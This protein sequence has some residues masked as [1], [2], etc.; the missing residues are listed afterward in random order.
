MKLRLPTLRPRRAKTLHYAIGLLLLAAVPFAQ[1]SVVS[2]QTE[3]EPLET[4]IGI[5]I[6]TFS[7]GDADGAEWAQRVASVLSADLARS[8]AFIPLPQTALAQD[9]VSLHAQPRFEAWRATNAE[10]LL[11]GRVTPA[12]G[13]RL[14]LALRLWHVPSGTQLLGEQYYSP[15][16]HWRRLAHVAADAIYSR[17]TGV[18]GYFDTRIAFIERRD[19]VSP[20]VTRLAVM[21]QDGTNL[22][23]LTSGAKP[24]LSVRFSPTSQ[25]LLFVTNT[26]GPPRLVLRDLQRDM[27]EVVGDFP[28]L[29]AAPRFAPDGHRIVM[30][31]KR[32]GNANLYAMNL[33]TRELSRLTSTAAIDTQPSV[34]PSGQRIVFVSQR[35]GT[36]QLYVMAAD[37]SAQQRISRGD[38]RYSDPVWSP[39]GGLIAFVKRLGG[40]AFLGV[41]KP[42]GSDERLLTRGA[43]IDGFAWA[44]NGR[45][46]VFSRIMP[47]NQGAPRL[48]TVTIDGGSEAVLETP[49]SATAPTWSPPLAQAQPAQP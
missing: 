13:G 12:Q 28:G 16:K 11:V 27:S 7:N 41:M 30:S 10:V 19:D 32:G 18:P 31:L 23:Y 29:I 4:P 39:T 2:A 17:L 8:Q 25:Q 6:P 48:V 3:A 45:V 21:D 33:R 35:S 38:G 24:I 22:E 40:E 46:I 5:A 43:D 37:G 20:P 26:G 14:R 15:R 1:V 49:G 36:P 47:Q 44:P 34:S 42:D 9:R